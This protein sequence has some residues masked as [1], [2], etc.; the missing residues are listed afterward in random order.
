MINQLV[1]QLINLHPLVFH[2]IIIL[3]SLIIVAK[4]SDLVVYGISN[5]A[6]KL[7]V[8]DYLI[9][10][11]VVSIGTAMPELIASI[12]G[13]LVG[14]GAIVFGTVL[15]SNLFKIPL[16]GLLLLIA[17]NIKIEQNVGMDAPIITLFVTASPLL[18]IIDGV[19]SKIDGAVL[20]IAF[21]IYIVRLWRGEGKLGKM[22]KDIKLKN[23]WK[24][25]IIFALSLAALLLSARWLVFSSIH[26]SEIL[27]ISPYIVGL[28]VIGVGA[29]TPELT[30]QLRS[31]FK[32]HQDIAFGNVLGSLV[33]NSA[34]VLGIAAIIKPIYISPST[35]F[36]A[37]IFM[38]A[39]TLY[40][41]IIMGRER[42]NWKHGW[43]LIS[44]YILFLLAE[45]IF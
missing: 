25:A 30:V 21:L 41:L 11:L 34:F 12:T 36:I 28:I 7:G 27:N 26:I 22:K 43:V 2:S 3:A 35:I 20:I 15:G 13:T 42:V 23:I 5:Y 10:F 44:F 17:K 29:S 1:D 37:S 45:F 38:I 24:D 39:G 31:I 19:L 8:S 6:K 9:G 40:T 16:L 32:H 4:S 14:Q 18:L 33:A